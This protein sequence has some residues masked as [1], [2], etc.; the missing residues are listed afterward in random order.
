[1]T[2]QIL[3]LLT[4]LHHHRRQHHLLLPLDPT[5]FHAISFAALPLSLLAE[6]V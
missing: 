2:S 5:M 1:M 3:L 6:R 4:L